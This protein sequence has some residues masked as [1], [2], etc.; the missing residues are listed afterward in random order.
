MTVGQVLKY[1]K[2]CLVKNG[3][4]EDIK[5]GNLVYNPTNQRENTPLSKNRQKHRL[6][7]FVIYQVLFT[8]LFYMNDLHRSCTS[9]LN[10]LRLDLTILLH[11]DMV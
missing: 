9:L 7:I 6:S 11:W 10:I 8:L 1:V 2:A 5:R 3:H 4:E